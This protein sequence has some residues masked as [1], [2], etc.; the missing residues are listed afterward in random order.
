MRTPLLVLWAVA[1]SAAP[2]PLHLTE[3]GATSY[4]IVISRTASPSEVRAAAELHNFLIEISGARLPVMA[5]DSH[6]RGNLVLI[7][8]SAITDRL[9][10]NI[11][12]DQ[13]GPEGFQIRTA[14]RHLV[15]AGGRQRGTMYGVYTFLE[16]L[17]C[18][19]IAP[20]ASRIPKLPSI[21]VPPLNET[22]KPAFEY[23]EVYMGEA[24]DKDWAS[25]NKT[26]GMNAA[27]DA[28]TGGKI[29]YYPFVHTFYAILPPQTYFK[30]HPEYYSLVDGR[31]RSEGAQLCLTNPD[32]L[33]L[34]VQKVLQWIKEHPEATIFSVSQNDFGGQCECDHCRLVTREEG[35]DSGP[36]LRFVNAVADKVGKQYP[37]KLIDTLAYFYSEAPPSKTR[38]RP[39]VRI[40]MCPIGACNAHP[41]EKCPYD[42]Y[43]VKNLRAWN[44][45]TSNIYVWHY[46]ANF[47][48]FLLPVPDF[49]ELAA[50]IPM[51]QRNG[52]K[53]LFMQGSNPSGGSDASLRAYVLARLLW[54]TH[55]DVPKA[56]DEFHE[57]YY[58]PAA[59]PMR[60]WFDLMQKL[61]REPPEGINMHWWCCRAPFTTDITL[62]KAHAIFRQALAAAPD[63]IIRTRVRRAELSLRYLELRRLQQFVVRDNIYQPTDL[64]RLRKLFPSFVSDSHR[65]GIT[66]W[67]EEADLAKD[68][69][70]FAGTLRSYPVVT[71][72]NAAL[73]VRLA[74]DLNGR[75]VSIASQ[76][77]GREMLN[78]PAS[79]EMNYPNRSGLSVSVY[80]DYVGSP[81]F[82]VEW[83]V[84]PSSNP[85]Q[86]L[87]TG[88]TARGLRLLRRIA[89]P[90]EDARIHTET[91]VENAS[92]QAV[93]TVLQ[94]QFDADAGLMGYAFIEF[95][96]L[97]GRPA[98]QLVIKT[99]AE[100]TGSQ[101]F[102]GP[103]SPAG[104]WRITNPS[105]GLQ[106]VNR[107]DPSQVARCLLGWSAKNA[108]RVS[109]GLWSARRTLR[110]GEVL[111]LNA[112][113]TLT[114]VLP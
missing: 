79:V 111:H 106:V 61:V 100:P 26:N 69:A 84:V 57:I 13:L 10:L 103:Q 59:A 105:A 39:N 104:E 45:I 14:G 77:T 28:S 5:D 15:I 29:Q 42:A 97:D 71:I 80:P 92:A 18:R 44:K 31:R 55:A 101:T 51:Y 3:N 89:L 58:G 21:T 16:K 112:D 17:G 50:D 73:S 64:N 96:S 52:V 95:T 56:I 19:W 60:A 49:D 109:L 7:G 27:L 98:R 41:Y 108:N 22:G 43:I 8:R 37:D 81:A 68:E 63:D 36:L 75:V 20:D 40:R 34:T 93:E 74:P 54:D 48:H 2:R 38:P 32:V 110:P 30:E 72:E 87:L 102:L 62:E 76:P 85:R 67:G 53:G 46:N 70:S 94:S 86:I 47:S 91:T 6:P 25:R 35:A 114:A 33:R 1:V 66:R 82:P 24:F 113:Y 4:T 9:K 23:R 107:F 83:R 12:F 65:L 78:Q 90:G 88:T 99:A 11:P